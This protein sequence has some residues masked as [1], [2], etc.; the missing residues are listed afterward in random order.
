[1]SFEYILFANT[2]QDFDHQNHIENRKYLK[3]TFFL[4]RCE[5]IHICC[6][7]R[8]FS[9]IKIESFVYVI[10]VCLQKR[11]FG[12]R[13]LDLRCSDLRNYAPNAI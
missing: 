5:P 8:L 10:D 13:D 12:L 1:M 2:K 3:H 7:K 6:A 11:N 9:V 4:G